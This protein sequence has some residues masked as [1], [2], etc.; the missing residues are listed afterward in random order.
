MQCSLISADHIQI[1]ELPQCWVMNFLNCH[2]LCTSLQMVHSSCGPTANSCLLSSRLDLSKT[3]YA[4]KYK[5]NC[6]M[7]IWYALAKA[8]HD[9]FRPFGDYTATFISI[10]LC[11]CNPYMKFCMLILCCTLIPSSVTLIPYIK[12]HANFSKNSRMCGC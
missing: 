11:A 7:V 6:F 10:F 2:V 8:F 9:E 1:T 12:L 3:L 4:T 5:C